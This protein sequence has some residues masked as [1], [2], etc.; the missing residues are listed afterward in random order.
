M[1]ESFP[2]NSNFSHRN[3]YRRESKMCKTL[4]TYN[5]FSPRDILRSE[6]EMRSESFTLLLPP[7]SHSISTPENAETLMDV[8]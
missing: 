7:E 4:K 8:V 2:S 6:M 1:Q 3:G 5:K